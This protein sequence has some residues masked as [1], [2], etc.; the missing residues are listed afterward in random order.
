M[1]NMNPVVHFE[2][3]Y[4]DKNRMA[5]FYAQ[6]FG[7]KHQMLGPEM[8]NYVVVTTSERDEKTGFPKNPGMINGGFF[9]KTKDVQYPSVVIAVDDI[10]Q[11][12][13]SVKEAGG[14]VLGGQKPGEPDNIPGVGLYASF[15]DTEG[16]RAGML[17]PI[18]M[19]GL[20]K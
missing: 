10:K 18:P 8:G 19:S 12:M 1:S 5:N 4:E 14:R 20:T 3:P 13:K 17:Q 11:A 9:A 16:N 2:M 6:A 15:I 7:W